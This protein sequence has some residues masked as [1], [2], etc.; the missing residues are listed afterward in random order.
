MK[1]SDEY[2]MLLRESVSESK[3]KC[4]M[5]CEWDEEDGKKYLITEIE[6]PENVNWI[7]WTREKE[8]ERGVAI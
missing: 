6:V 1:E 2:A 8:G 5:W 3:K 4:W 7:K